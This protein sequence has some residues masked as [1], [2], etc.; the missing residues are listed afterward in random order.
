[1]YQNVYLLKAC[2]VN[3]QFN[4][5]KCDFQNLQNSNESDND[6]E[7][8]QVQSFVSSFLIY[9]TLLENLPGVF[10][11][12]F[13]G[14]LSDKHGRKPLMISFICGFV[15][16]TVIMMANLNFDSW[17]VEYTLFGSI[18]FGLCGGAGSFYMASS[19]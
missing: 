3:F 10:F 19:R 17:P 18:I 6:E 8:N 2:R 14:P 1:M 16:E 15:M 4:A 5:T 12:L 11:V 9:T 7:A 13:L